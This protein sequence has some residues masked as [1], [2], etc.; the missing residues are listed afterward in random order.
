VREFIYQKLFFNLKNKFEEKFFDN[1][2][3]LASLEKLHKR[4]KSEDH[5][6]DIKG[7]DRVLSS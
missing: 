6:E 7:A 3:K 2:S 1:D 5:P 4:P